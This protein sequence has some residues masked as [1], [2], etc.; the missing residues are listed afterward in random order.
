MGSSAQLPGLT[1]TVAGSGTPPLT[2]IAGLPEQGYGALIDLRL[3]SEPGYAEE[4]SAAAAAGLRWIAVPISGSNFDLA[5]AAAL[6]A[7]LDEA[8]DAKVLL[9]CRSGSRVG[10]LW[11]L[12]QATD[13]GLTPTEAE[14][15]ALTSG[16]APRLALRVREQ[17]IAAQRRP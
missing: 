17:L 12:M 5:D 1:P 11:A 3:P 4:R 6:R 9:H 13:Q 2:A 8:G 15:L 10:A 7:A 14:S 16:A